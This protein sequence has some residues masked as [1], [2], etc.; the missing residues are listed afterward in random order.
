MS[1]LR[2]A[3]S[4]AR[5]RRRGFPIHAYVGANGGGKS[6]SAV[7][8]TLPT[9]AAGRPVLSTVRLLD[10][11]ARPCDGWHGDVECAL[12]GTSVP[13]GDLGPG[14]MKAHPLYR[15]LSDYR[16]LMDAEHC[17]VLMDEV[18]G[19][20]SSRDSSSMPAPVANLL[21]Q[22]RRRDVA[23]RWTAPSWKR[24]DT[25]IRE[26][27][28]AVT[29]CYGF[30]PQSIK[31]DDGSDRLWSSRR[32]FYWRTYDAATFDEWTAHKRERLRPVTRQLMW[33]P[34]S[35]AESAYDTFDAVLSL[36][37]VTEGG[38]CLE[39]GGARQRPG[40]TCL[41]Y[42]DRRLAAADAAGRAKD[43]RKVAD[44]PSP[45]AI[46]AGGG[47]RIAIAESDDTPGVVVETA[48]AS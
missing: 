40:C 7:Y 19:V 31:A 17:D 3:P 21:V 10:Y 35:V 5:R 47:R 34:G 24:A 12:C 14:H 45:V 11:P 44:L 39:C 20:A 28:Q 23:L 6:L 27:S 1:D 38:S 4:R 32:L 48:A 22:L 25:I 26:C 46:G 9:L 42:L 36:G 29:I 37:Q 30:A 43:A 33:R 2:I 8:D 16:Q 41:D 15:P 18:T 13:T